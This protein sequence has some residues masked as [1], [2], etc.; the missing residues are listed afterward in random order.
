MMM[1]MTVSGCVSGCCV[2]LCAGYGF[3]GT[4]VCFVFCCTG[5]EFT[6]F[7][8]L[9]EREFGATGEKKQADDCTSAPGMGRPVCGGTAKRA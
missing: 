4:S 5:L 6:R 9:R 1:T 2:S 7:E 8:F 3:S